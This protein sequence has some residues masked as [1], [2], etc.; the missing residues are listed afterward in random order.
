MLVVSADTRICVDRLS[1]LIAENST[2]LNVSISSAGLL[3]LQHVWYIWCS[4][5]NLG[6]SGGDCVRSTGDCATLLIQVILRATDRVWLM[7]RVC[8]LGCLCLRTW[9]RF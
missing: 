7:P 3:L 5:N 4:Q 9:K 1:C 6:L 2:L 8:A